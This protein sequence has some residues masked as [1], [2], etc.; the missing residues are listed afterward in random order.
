MGKNSSPSADGAGQ[1]ASKR[2]QKMIDWSKEAV[3]TDTLIAELERRGI[4]RPHGSEFW[5]NDMEEQ[6]EH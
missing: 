5:F 3:E 1:L 4:R 6:S 2:R